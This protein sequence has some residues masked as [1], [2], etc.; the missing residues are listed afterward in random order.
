MGNPVRFYRLFPHQFNLRRSAQ[1]KAVVILGFALVAVLIAALCFGAVFINPRQLAL[2]IGHA[3]GFFDVGILPVHETILLDLRLPR[4]LSAVLIGASLGAGGAAMQGLFRNPLADPM[5]TGVSAGAA[6]AAIIFI[7]LGLTATP[8]TGVVLLPVVSFVG[9]LIAVLIIYGVSS[10]GGQAEVVSILLA[11]IAF[12]ALAAAVIGFFTVVADNTELRSFTFW[13]LGSLSSVSWHQSVAIAVLSI[14][15][16]AAIFLSRC[17][18]DVL[19][20]GERNAIYLGIRIERWKFIVIVAV[21]LGVGASVAVAGII[22]FVGLVTPHL[23]R[24]VIGPNHTVLLPASM[25]LGALFTL[26]ADLAARTVMLP[27]EL[28]ISVMTA[29]A[30][31]PLFVFLMTSGCLLRRTL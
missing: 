4:V 2:G 21:A 27:I 26:L 8:I 23:V 22:S 12:N 28:P 13:M 24:M 6:M 31:I 14:P 30:G 7:M 11:G 25:L 17:A 9:G 16:L 10:R 29:L 20:L 18:L 1:K 19:V 3:L 15:A 5:L